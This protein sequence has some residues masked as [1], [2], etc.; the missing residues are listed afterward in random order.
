MALPNYQK[1]F[2]DLKK[3]TDYC[4]NPNHPVGKSKARIFKSVLQIERNDAELLKKSILKGLSIHEALIRRSD[5]YGQLYQVDIK[6]RNLNLEAI[7][8][9]VWIVEHD[10][11]VP[12]LITC[13]I[14]R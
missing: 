6:I 9:T 14:R 11:R 4:L 8:T 2:I 12:R 13:Y 7:V 5:E 3:L 1:A 10:E